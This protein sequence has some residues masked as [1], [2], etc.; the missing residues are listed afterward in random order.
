MQLTCTPTFTT[1]SGF[2]NI[3]GLPVTSNGTYGGAMN[4]NSSGITYPVGTTM[5]VP[6]PAG[7]LFTLE[8]NGSA[9]GGA[10]MSTTA[11]AS[12]V[13]FNLYMTCIYRAA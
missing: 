8:A 13:Q 3:T 7:T 11:V 12:G 1:S 2:I 6:N 10:K 4:F 5:V 9:V